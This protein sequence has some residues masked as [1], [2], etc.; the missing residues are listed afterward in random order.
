MTFGSKPMAPPPLR[1]RPP[2][3]GDTAFAVGSRAL[4]TPAAPGREVQL[5]DEDGMPTLNRWHAAA[6]V[7]IFAINR[8]I[9]ACRT[10]GVK[11][12]FDSG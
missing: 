2:S 11:M 9:C 1:P 4:I 7:G 10:S 12:S 6:R 8:T 3:R 5:L